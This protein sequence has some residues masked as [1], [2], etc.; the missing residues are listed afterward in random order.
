[1]S[2]IVAV[3]VA[4]VVDLADLAVAEE[5]VAV[6]TAVVVAGVADQEEVVTTV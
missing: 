6:V 3:L 4:M 5:A 2:V 1:V